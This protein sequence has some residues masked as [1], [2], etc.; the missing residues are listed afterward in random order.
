MKNTDCRSRAAQLRSPWSHNAPQVFLTICRHLQTA[1]LKPYPTCHLLHCE[2]S[3]GQTGSSWH[4]HRM[5]SGSIIPRLSKEDGVLLFFPLSLCGLA[6]RALS[7]GKEKEAGRKQFFPAK[8]PSWWKPILSYCV[9]LLLR[10]HILAH[11]LC[12]CG[13]GLRA[14]RLC[15]GCILRRQLK[16]SNADIYSSNFTFSNILRKSKGCV[17]R[18]AICN[19]GT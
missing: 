12:A 2:K 14:G 16:I 1:D 7:A 5:N 19:A 3:P 4:F 6:E 11:N 15:S 18:S 13:K 9:K 8:P 10:Q 17:I